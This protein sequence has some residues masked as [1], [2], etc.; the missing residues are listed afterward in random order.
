[1]KMTAQAPRSTHPSLATP[2]AR[3]NPRASAA[4]R[5]KQ[6]ETSSEAIHALLAAGETARV[7]F[8]PTV[9]DAFEVSRMIAGFANAEGGLIL[10]GAQPPDMLLGCNVH[11]A[12]RVYEE[13]RDLLEPDPP[14]AFHT[15]VVDGKPLAAI[16]VGK[17]Q[18]VVLSVGGAFVR[19]DGELVP[20]SAGDL[21]L[22]ATKH[23]ALM[24]SSQARIAAKTAPLAREIE[25]IV[26]ATVTPL[27]RAIVQQ[28]EIIE[29]LHDDLAAA[30]R[31][32]SRAKE[33]FISAVV[34]A[35]VA[36]FLAMIFG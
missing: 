14:S 28:T 22:L 11:L 8:A 17:A 6:H 15:L 25:P 18:A 10:F 24:S 26:R 5:P 21:T 35:V 34:G 2:R 29:R 13:A 12:E 7:T 31:F 30:A 23:A 3:P 20:M 16:K 4:P 36:Q 1:M 19:R 32:E 33:W 9:G 27:A